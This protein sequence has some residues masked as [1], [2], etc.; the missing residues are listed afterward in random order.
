MTQQVSRNTANGLVTGAAVDSGR[1]VSERGTGGAVFAATLMII[2]GCF[3]MLQGIR[4][5]G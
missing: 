2:G 1:T 5:A 4:A 3:G